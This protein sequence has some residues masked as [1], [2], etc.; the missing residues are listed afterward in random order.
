MTTNATQTMTIKDAS[1]KLGV[2]IRTL[3]RQI[4]Q[5]KYKSKLLKGKRYVA[6]PTTQTA[7]NDAPMSQDN[8]A[9]PQP[10]KTAEIPT[11]P[12][13]YILID[14]AT[15]EDLRG[16]LKELTTSVREMQS[17][18]KLLIEKGLG[19]QQL[20]APTAT[21]ST[22]TEPRQ[23]NDNVIVDVVEVSPIKDIKKN[24]KHSDTHA[25][26]SQDVSQQAEAPK[27]ATQATTEVNPEPVKTKEWYNKPFWE[28]F[29]K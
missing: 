12:Q 16:Q 17:T 26:M 7:T 20:Q 14:K 19:L 25:K 4:K 9:P 15:L 23:D 27:D 8:V 6:I 2:T 1:E 22:T 3:Q 10:K 29:K 13:G 24:D 28:I 18:Q 11:I 5:G 21:T